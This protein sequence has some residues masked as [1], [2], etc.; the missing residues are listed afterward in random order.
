L[1]HFK[2]LEKLAV[3][4][5]AQITLIG[6]RNN[7]GKSS[8]LEAIFLVLDRANPELL[9]RHFSWRG[10][11]IVPAS[12]DAM[13][14]PAFSNYDFTR[15]IKITLRNS[16]EGHEVMTIRYNPSY[17]HQSLPLPSPSREVDK[18]HSAKSDLISQPSKALDVSVK[19]G[20]Q[21]VLKWHLIITP[22][23]LNWQVERA[24]PV[25]RPGVFIGSTHRGSP[26]EDSQRFGQLDIQRNTQSLVEVVRTIEPRIRS[27]SVVAVGDQALIHADLEGMERKIP[28]ALL[29]DGVSRLLTIALAIFATREGIV[30]VDEIEN[31]IHHSALIPLWTALG[32][33]ANDANCQLI[34]TTHSYECLLAASRALEEQHDHEFSYV[35]L[36]RKKSTGEI[37]G[38]TYSLRELA[39][40]G[41]SELEVR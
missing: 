26:R 11:P 40:A 14:R 6:G 25:D 10:I 12:D 22:T 31:G 7:V 20:K 1:E 34:A 24:D 13:W 23:G 9:L 32:K 33:A 36:D 29:G 41:E 30:L 8:L 4:G 19:V 2:G 39:A 27:L 16:T 38:V 37:V 15:N 17:Q 18:V 3:Q 21:T 28:V 35:R 5:L